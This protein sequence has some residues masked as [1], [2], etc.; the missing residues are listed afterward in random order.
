MIVIADMATQTLA[1]RK[2]ITPI[3]KK[4]GK[5]MERL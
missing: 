3:Y 5:N 1:T 2:R 4:Y